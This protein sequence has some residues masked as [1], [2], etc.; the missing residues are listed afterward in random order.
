[1]AHRQDVGMSTTGLKMA[2]IVQVRDGF[3][4]KDCTCYLFKVKVHVLKEVLS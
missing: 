1:M 3:A 4:T 2:V